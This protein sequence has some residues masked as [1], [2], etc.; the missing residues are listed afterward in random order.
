MLSNVIEFKPLR[1][2]VLPFYQ[3][4]L[5]SFLN[6]I[7]KIFVFY[8]EVTKEYEAFTG[9]DYLMMG[10]NRFSISSQSLWPLS[11]T[12]LYLL[13]TIVSIRFGAVTREHLG[14]PN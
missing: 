4:S 12:I 1:L 9:I 11:F 10:N 6:W 3:P 13:L 14:C 7:C 2:I 5:Q 8:H